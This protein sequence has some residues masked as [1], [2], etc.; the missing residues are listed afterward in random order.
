M[1]NAIIAT[2]ENGLLKP[3]EKLPLSEH[4]KVL[5]VVVPLTTE[6]AY[7]RDPAR[8]AKM[9]ERTETWLSQQSPDATREPSAQAAQQRDDEFDAALAAIRA[10]ASHFDKA[11]IIADVEAAISE[12]RAMPDEERARLNRELT[13]MLAAQSA[14]ATS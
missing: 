2:Y 14:D 13:Q 3:A 1:T 7:P 8:L 9:R 12:V 5:V 6:T 4:Q 11:Q 10:R